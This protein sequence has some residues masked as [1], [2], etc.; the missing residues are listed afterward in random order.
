M[1]NSCPSIPTPSLSLSAF[2]YS[3][4]LL[5]ISQKKRKT[6]KMGS[7]LISLLPIFHLLVLLGSSVNAYW[8]PS[9]GYWPSSKVVSLSFYKGFRNLWGPQHQRMD[10]NALTIWLDR[11]SG[12]VIKLC[13]SFSQVDI[14][15]FLLKFLFL[16]ID[17][18]FGLSMYRKWI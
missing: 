5:S 8:P 18:E 17:N 1:P 2:I 16:F 9:P 4:L 13:F 3:I 15:I 14:S 12:T 10:Q 7:S 6:T 11:T